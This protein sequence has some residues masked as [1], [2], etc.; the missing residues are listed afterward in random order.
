MNRILTCFVI[1]VFLFSCSVNK[2]KDVVRSYWENGNVK[3][4]LRYKDGKLDG[5]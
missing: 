4:E 2:E 3:S 5:D 1:C